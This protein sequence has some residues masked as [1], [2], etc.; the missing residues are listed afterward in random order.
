MLVSSAPFAAPPNNVSAELTSRS[1]IEFLGLAA[2][3]LQDCGH[4]SDHTFA[5]LV[6]D[7]K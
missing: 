7:R 2:V 5:P 1:A 3:Q 4:Q 6:H